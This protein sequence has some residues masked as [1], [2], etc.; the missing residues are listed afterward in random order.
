[1][2]G[3][4]CVCVS[5]RQHSKQHNRLDGD[6]RLRSGWMETDDCKLETGGG[7]HSS[8]AVRSGS[9]DG[10][11]RPGPLTAPHAEQEPDRADQ[12][13]GATVL[14]W[15]RNAGDDAGVAGRLETPGETKKWSLERQKYTV[16][17]LCS[18]LDSAC[19]LGAS[20]LLL[21]V[22]RR[23]PGR[24]RGWTGGLLGDYGNPSQDEARLLRKDGC[25]FFS[26]S[27]ASPHQM[28]LN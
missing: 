17:M 14:F 12:A 3:V 19:L 25:F 10:K 15:R 21:L 24:R 13:S 27:N 20:L 8:V 4:V 1:M 7:G 18:K 6:W 22:E 9:W 11:P 28:E 16:I 5:R 26:P 23:G 2:C